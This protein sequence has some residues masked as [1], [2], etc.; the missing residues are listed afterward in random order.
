MQ[1]DKLVDRF[2]EVLQI[3]QMA[4]V[5]TVGAYRRDLRRFSEFLNGHGL[6][7]EEIARFPQ[8]LLSSGLKPRSAARMCSAVKVFLKFLA[9]EEVVAEDLSRAIVSLRT[10]RTLPD[11]LSQK[12]VSDLFDRVARASG[13]GAR[14]R[15]ILELLYGSGLRASELAGLKLSD[16][17]LEVGYVRVLGKGEKERVVPMGRG[18]RAALE[19]YLR[20]ERPSYRRAGRSEFVFLSF[21]GSKLARETVWRTVKKCQALLGPDA[22]LYPHLFRHC[23]ATHIMENGT[24]VRLVQDLLGHSSIA[25]TQVYTHVDRG[26]LKAIHRKFHPRG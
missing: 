4:S 17:N 22:R 8:H 23:F 2:L 1:L 25:T 26:R 20:D 24:D 19:E 6:D 10:P 9:R 18:A 5:H 12:D 3:E 13:L 15:A 14:G 11:V 7:R 16:V 21:K